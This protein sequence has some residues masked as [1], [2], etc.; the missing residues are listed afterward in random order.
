M[1]SFH[2]AFKKENTQCLNKNQFH[3]TEFLLWFRC[4][5]L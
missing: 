3:T 5:C 4:R 1:H 2:S